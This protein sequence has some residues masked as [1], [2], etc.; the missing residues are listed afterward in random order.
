MRTTRIK[1]V[2]VDIVHTEARTYSYCRQMP[3]VNKVVSDHETCT[4]TAPGKY[5][6]AKDE[7]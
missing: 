2:M 7:I 3:V 6:Q 4:R 5:Q 1:R